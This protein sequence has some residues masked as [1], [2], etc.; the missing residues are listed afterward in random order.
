MNVIN[1]AHYRDKNHLA[2]RTHY[3]PVRPHDPAD[4]VLLAKVTAC[5]HAP[6][7]THWEIRAFDCSGPFHCYFST[8]D[9]LHLQLWNPYFGVSLLTP[10]KLTAGNYEAFPLDEWKYAAKSYADISEEIEGRF[11]TKLPQLNCVEIIAADYYSAY[12]PGTPMPL[13]S[14]IP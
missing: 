7:F 12:G 6:K 8:H 5:P 2:H 9:M 1:L 3:A 13:D 10:S 4:R 11:T 14:L